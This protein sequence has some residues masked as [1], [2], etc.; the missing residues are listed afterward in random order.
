MVE[1]RT[2]TH[3]TKDQHVG[4]TGEDYAVVSEELQ[5]SP[6]Q[7]CYHPADRE[8]GRDK[9]GE[10][11]R[12]QAGPAVDGHQDV[13][14]LEELPERGRRQRDKSQKEAEFHSRRQ[15]Q[16]KEQATGNR[17]QATADAWPQSDRLGDSR[18]SR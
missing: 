5:L 17:H 15:A 3:F 10:K 6:A 12:G 2:R 1:R 13:S 4:R 7:K 9:G 14:L 11:A 8:G 18:M 16:A